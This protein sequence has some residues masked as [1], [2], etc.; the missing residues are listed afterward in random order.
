TGLSKSITVIDDRWQFCRKD[1]QKIIFVILKLKR[2]YRVMPIAVILFWTMLLEQKINAQKDSGYFSSF[3]KVKIWYHVE[4]KGKPVL[5]IHGF[6]GKG[7]DWKAKPLYDTLLANGFKV[8]IADLRGNGLS[9]KPHTAEAYANDAEAKDLMGLLKFL[10]IRKYQAIGYSRGSIVL[11]RLLVMDKN[12]TRAVIGGMGAD[13]THPMW[14]RRIGIYEALMYDS[15]KGYDDFKKRIATSGLDRLALAY[16]QKEQPSTSKEEL[17]KIRQ[18][19]LIL[20][21][22]QDEDN[23][24]A[25]DLQQLIPGSELVIVP[26]NHGSAAG[27]REFASAS[28]SFLR[29]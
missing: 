18:R 21:G 7:N 25:Q 11:A 14:P 24:K 22:D 28:L 27:T 23:G 15:V 8:V 6:T 29:K 17:S 9:D 12:I 1:L 3:D 26:G 19:V 20:C 13:F 5:L 16:Q 4:G 10:H 2:M